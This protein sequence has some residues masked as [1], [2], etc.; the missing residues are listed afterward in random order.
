MRKR[1]GEKERNGRRERERERGERDSR[2]IRNT[3]T[4]ETQVYLRGMI[5]SK[6][7]CVGGHDLGEL[8][9]EFM[10]LPIVRIID[11]KDGQMRALI[12]GPSSV[13]MYDFLL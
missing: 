6:T 12:G 7:M 3:C 4:L 11:A 1:D 8:T 5:S 10:N 13:L 2:K 9:C